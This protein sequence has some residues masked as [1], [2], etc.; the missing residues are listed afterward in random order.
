MPRT[1]RA[2]FVGG[3]LHGRTEIRP[4]EPFVET[5]EHNGPLPTDL[6]DTTA[7]EDVSITRIAYRQVRL[8]DLDGTEVA[9]YATDDEM[10]PRAR[11]RGADPI[12]NVTVW[13]LADELA[14]ARQRI[15]ELEDEL[16]ASRAR[17]AW[18]VRHADGLV[19]TLRQVRD[20][21]TVATS[22]DD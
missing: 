10:V 17:E 8:V 11:G 16:R 20:E 12:P 2:L 7:W 21:L 14:G 5:V 22:G 19:G 15:R 6:G 4:D 9:I 18:A 1:V 3:P 13:A